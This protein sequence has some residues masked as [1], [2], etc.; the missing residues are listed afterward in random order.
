M[1]PGNTKL[2]T[3]TTRQAVVPQTSMS[4]DRTSFSDETLSDDGTPHEEGALEDLLSG[5]DGTDSFTDDRPIQPA[6]PFVDRSVSHQRAS[7]PR[8]SG[9]AS[10][11]IL[12]VA[13]MLARSQEPSL[14][15][16]AEQA[17]ESGDDN[18]SI[19]S[20]SER[21]SGANV[22]EDSDELEDTPRAETDQRE[23][24]VPSV[25]APSSPDIANQTGR[26]SE[27]YSDSSSMMLPIPRGPMSP[28]EMDVGGLVSDARLAPEPPGVFSL[29]LQNNP[30]PS[31]GAGG[32]NTHAASTVRNFTENEHADVS[33][34]EHLEHSDSHQAIGDEDVSVPLVTNMNDLALEP[35]DD[36]AAFFSDAGDDMFLPAPPTAD[37]T[38]F[39]TPS[40]EENRH[41]H[42]RPMS[43]LWAASQSVDHSASRQG[44]HIDDQVL[45]AEQSRAALE[46]LQTAQQSHERNFQQMATQQQA[47]SR[48]GSASSPARNHFQLI[49]LGDPAEAETPVYNFPFQPNFWARDSSHLQAPPAPALPASRGT[50]EHDAITEPD[51]LLDT[52]TNVSVIDV[53]QL[54]QPHQNQFVQTNPS[55]SNAQDLTLHNQRESSSNAVFGIR[56][57]Q[58]FKSANI[59]SSP[60]LGLQSQDVLSWAESERVHRLPH[61]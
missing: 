51:V 44:S 58:S 16:A 24:R 28:P 17:H 56:P 32:L 1:T 59:G 49:R 34:A 52:F 10:R 25:T 42:P 12:Q 30:L 36:S 3:G 7:G 2:Q 38:I 29:T 5:I 39:S 33:R 20:E 43:S 22:G 14:Y 53:R 45:Q 21:S 26:V 19:L 6:N 23:V 61:S 9:P 11:T 18:T 31:T 8:A 60:A 4:Q 35:P 54:H 57:A 27:M 37:I 13:D 15:V 46:N 47:E 50:T 48:F 41:D 55:D 40:S